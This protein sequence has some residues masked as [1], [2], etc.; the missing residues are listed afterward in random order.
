MLD[1]V[2]AN[3]S[4]SLQMWES[5]GDPYSGDRIETL[6]EC[7]GLRVKS[8]GASSAL[9]FGADACIDPS[10]HTIR[11]RRDLH[12]QYQMLVGSVLLVLAL[13]IP[14]FSMNKF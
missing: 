1:A 12:P 14:K 3:A 13:C 8:V 7:Y 4:Q 5:S 10:T 9:L 6:L 2:S 11:I